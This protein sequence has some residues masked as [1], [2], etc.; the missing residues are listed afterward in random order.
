MNLHKSFKVNGPISSTK[1]MVEPKPIMEQYNKYHEQGLQCSIDPGAPAVPQGARE[2]FDRHGYLIIKNLYDPK[3]L[4]HPVPQERGQIDY[5][6]KESDQFNHYPKEYQVNGSLSRYNYPQ[7]R[8]IESKI[9]MILEDILGEKLYTTYYYDR[10][11]FVG[12]RLNRH[13]DRDICKISVSIQIST[14]AFI[15]WPLCIEDSYG[16]E[17]SINL[18]DG[19]GLLY[20]GCEREHWRDPLQ[21]RYNKFGRLINRIFRKDDDTYHHQIFF[22]YVNVKGPK[23]EGLK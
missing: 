19:W 3:E 20:K 8:E 5:W 2:Y 12:Q 21:S 4:Y 16:E 13:S 10:Y 23:V 9:R 14:N 18:K 11:Y 22:H 6:G 15:P 7:Y 17:C 1:E